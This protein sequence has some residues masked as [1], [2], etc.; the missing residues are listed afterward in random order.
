MKTPLCF[1]PQISSTQLPLL[2]F[3]YH[4]YLQGTLFDSEMKICNWSGMVTCNTMQPTPP[5]TPKVAPP[6]PSPPPGLVNNPGTPVGVVVAGSTSNGDGNIT[7]RPTYGTVSSSQSLSLDAAGTFAASEPV[8]TAAT[9]TYD[10]APQDDQS[11]GVARL[12]FTPTDDAYVQEDEPNVNFHNCP[13]T[14]MICDPRFVVVDANKRF[15]GLLRFYVQGIDGRHIEYVKLRLYVRDASM[16]GGNFYKSNS[17]WHEDVVTWD[18]V[19]SIIGNQPL[20]VVNAVLVNQWIEV[21]VT[22]LVQ[23]DGPVSIRITS[24]SDD[25][26]MYES[27]ENDDGNAPELI[28]GVK[29]IDLED[30][31]NR[32]G[33]D[34]STITNNVKIGVTDDA[35]VYGTM[36]KN[37]Y[38]QNEDLKVDMNG[39]KK[40]YLRFDLSRVHPD[41]IQ[42]AKL[43]LYATDSSSSGGTFVTVTDSNWNED[44]ITYDD[45]PPADGLP[46]G[47]LESVT[48]GQ[49]YELDITQAITESVP[50]TICILGNH[51]DNVH[52]SSKEGE[53]SP[54]IVLT[55][56]E[57]VPLSI[58]SSKV[59]ELIPT[60]DATIVLQDPDTNFNGDSLSADAKDGMRNFLMRFDASDVPRGEVNSAVL[61][62]YAMNQ[63]P[64][65]GGTFVENRRTEWNEQTVTWNTAPASDGKVL[66]SLMAVE[67]GSYYTIDVTSAVIGGSA[68][69]FRVSSPHFNEAM[70]GSKESDYKPRLIVQYSPPAPIPQDMDLYIPTD[71]TSILMDSPN[72]NYGRNTELKV[73]GYGGVFNSLLRFDLS[74][75]EKGTVVKAM[76]RLYSVDGSPSGGTFVVT[77]NTEWS[78]H[79]VTWNTAPAADGDII[80]TLGEVVPYQW[81]EIDLASIVQD[82]G[83]GY[84][85]IRIT[86]SHGL[87]CAYSS[88]EDRLGHLPQLLLQSDM[89]AGIG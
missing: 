45:A 11:D 40:S 5:P 14:T 57:V 15:D 55:L 71:D 34:V 44:T 59:V 28:V 26:V 42:S 13:D 84:L 72:K 8:V 17:E 46:L 9:T 69:S 51:N 36:P 83:G 24:D 41:S 75:V 67:Y 43:R 56:L 25:N 3:V 6:V 81:Y 4:Y 74:E 63:E 47:M 30:I 7:P 31:Q 60:D 18:T 39:D 1:K 87:R 64:A 35:F 12:R 19:P 16:F 20:A 52:Y 76:L 70:Y 54:E 23:A 2:L 10:D 58:Q 37:N 88:S 53:H 49:W 73:D 78:Q 29:S 21:D 48:A 89:F 62:M 33:D 32:G 22:G 61:R 65:F 82:L 50:L 38:G 68:V 80:D 85:S 27:K 86:P 66:G 79:S 77:K